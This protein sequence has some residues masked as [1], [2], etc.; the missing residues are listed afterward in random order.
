MHHQVQKG[1][2]FAHTLKDTSVPGKVQRRAY[3]TDGGSLYHMASSQ[4]IS[5]VDGRR[6]LEPVCTSTYRKVKLRQNHGR[7]AS[8]VLVCT[9]DP[10]VRN[11]SGGNLH[12]SYSLEAAYIG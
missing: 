6:G 10:R 4:W 2:R 5:K 11:S 3:T 7:L 12:I 8:Y 9:A 1:S